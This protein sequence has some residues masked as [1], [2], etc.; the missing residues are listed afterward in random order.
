MVDVSV[1][2]PVNN[3]EEILEKNLGRICSSLEKS[4]L[5]GK[6]EI[7]LC[8]NGSKDSTPVIIRNLSKKDQKIK[9]IILK[10]RGLGLAIKKG[11]LNA[12]YDIA[13]FYAIDIPFGADHIVHSLK[14][15]KSSDADIVIGSKT[16]H[17][18]STVRPRERTILSKIYHWLVVLFFDVN[19]D[20]QGSL[21]F[22]KSKIQV[23]LPVL[24][25]STSFF[26][27]EL[28]VYSKLYN[29]RII[30]IPVFVRDMR[31]SRIRSFRDGTLMFFALIK[32]FFRY[33]H[34]KH[35]IYKRDYNKIFNSGKNM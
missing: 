6:F 12:R 23:F 2:I 10:K 8:E 15:L 34:Y 18:S 13:V 16:H 22:R 3:E 7:I 21:M 25:A 5:V 33:M 35:S 31:D 30:E 24:K 14:A 32:C 17:K 28:I 4:K 1:I 20:T 26:N 9:P 11:I 27:T 19:E 29:L